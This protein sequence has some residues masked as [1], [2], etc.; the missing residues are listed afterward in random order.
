M[1]IQTFKTQFDTHFEK[2]IDQQINHIRSYQPD[3]D[4]LEIRSYL[5]QYIQGGKR[6][7]PYL[8]T[9]TYLWL[10]GTSTPIEQLF[11]IG[12]AHELVHTFALIHDDIMDQGSTRHGID[13]YHRFA[14][15]HYQINADHIGSSQAILVG[16]LVFYL[17]FRTFQQAT[18]N[19]TALWQFYQMLDEVIVWQSMDVHLSA[20]PF[21]ASHDTI[22]HKDLLKSANYTFTRPMM[23]GASLAEADNHQLEQVESIWQ[24]LW[25]AYQM[26]DDLMDVI[27]GH[28]NKTCFSDLQEGNQTYLFAKVLEQLSPAQQQQL[29]ALRGRKLSSQEQNL[30]LELVH[31]TNA[32]EDTKL[33]IN[34]HLDSASTRL[35]VLF[36]EQSNGIEGVIDYLRV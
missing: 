25:I 30:A 22:R 11:Q 4:L 26:R 29:L 8:V 36:G 3:S 5:A 2:F 17:A 19:P 35:A 13:T 15:W 20:T 18:N 7:R 14:A 1:D 24:T 6:V 28:D 21:E 32:I 16:D 34:N 27:A 23:V 12:I 31:A 33:A 9:E 10:T